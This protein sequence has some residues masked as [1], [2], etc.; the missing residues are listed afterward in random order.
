MKHKV[1]TYA[2]MVGFLVGNS[3]FASEGDVAASKNLKIEENLHLLQKCWLK[4]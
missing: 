2:C 4:I 3:V 1:L